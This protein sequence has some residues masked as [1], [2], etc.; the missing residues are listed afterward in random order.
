MAR[1]KKAPRETSDYLAAAKKL[2]KFVPSLAKYKRRKTLTRYEKSA[3][4][5]REKQ[6]R[7]VTDKLFPISKKQ[8]KNL[9]GKTF[10]HGVRA[11]ELRGTSA[12]AKIRSAGKDIMVVS[13]GRTWVYWGLNKDTVRQKRGMKKTAKDAFAMQFPIEKVSELARAAFKKL[14][15]IQI[16]LWAHSGVVGEPFETLGAFIDWIDEK[17]NAG[18]YVNEKGYSS[19][20]GAWINGIAILVKET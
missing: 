7:F 20:P 17:W 3:I 4:T 15:P 18:R 9:K 14:K 16:H 1:R 8:A 11:V 6:L 12:N 19:D 5:R 2:A 13:N 10:A